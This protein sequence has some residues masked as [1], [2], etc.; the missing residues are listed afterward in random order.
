MTSNETTKYNGQH[1]TGQNVEI[2]YL[3]YIFTCH[4]NIK[5]VFQNSVAFDNFIF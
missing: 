1:K 5:M 3:L 4:K 2:A